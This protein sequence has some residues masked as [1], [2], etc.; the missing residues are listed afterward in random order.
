MIT[1]AILFVLF[2]F[3][4]F[5]QVKGLGDASRIGRETTKYLSENIKKPS[6]DSSWISDTIEKV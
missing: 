4:S 3:R 5:R 1:L 2:A 6:K